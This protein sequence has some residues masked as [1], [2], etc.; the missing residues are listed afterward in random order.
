MA[1]SSGYTSGNMETQIENFLDYLSAERGLSP[2]TIK[3][4]KNDLNHFRTYLAKRR[5]RTVSRIT[6]SHITG[7]VR[8]EMGRGLSARSVARALVAVKMF[9][10]FL[11]FDGVLKTSPAATIEA[12]STWKR[13]PPVL[14]TKEVVSIIEAADGE[15][16]LEIRNRAILEVMYAA[17]LRATEVAALKREDFNMEYAYLRCRGKGSKERVV[18]VGKP[19]RK[20]VEAFLDEPRE[21]LL[22]GKER[23]ELF[24]TARGGPLS[25]QTVWRIIKKYALRA[26]LSRKIYPHTLRHTFATH[27]LEGGANLRAVQEMLGHA[28]I[29]TT[30]IYTHVD[31]K[32]LKAIHRKYHPRP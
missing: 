19:A 25:R 12:P 11:T 2:N 13:V 28:D 30:Q 5:V 4:Y 22:R 26:G 24:V 29:S 20:A 23:S 14:S 27:L 16:D 32:R 9:L 31:R 18:P 17:G 10:A 21:R 3:S 7:F 1:S 8:S 15:E 6:Q